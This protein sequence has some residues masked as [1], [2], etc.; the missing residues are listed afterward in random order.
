MV[1]DILIVEESPLRHRPART[2]NHDGVV[3]TT[4]VDQLPLPA[5]SVSV[6]CVV[7]AT[8]LMSGAT[9][10]EES[11]AA[12]AVVNVEAEPKPPRMPAA[13]VAASR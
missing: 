13:D 6:A 2:V 4:V 9:T 7:G 5:M 1:G 8:A 3:P 10:G 12:L 11:A